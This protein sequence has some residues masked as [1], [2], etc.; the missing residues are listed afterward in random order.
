MAFSLGEPEFMSTSS[1]REYCQNGR[2]LIRP[3]ANELHI[4]SE[5]LKA[6]LKEVPGGPV[7]TRWR[8]RVV[9]AHLG[10]AAHGVELTCAGL[11]RTFL[12]FERHFINN[13]PERTKHFDLMR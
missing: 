3:L 8:A 7:E 6:A 13:T 9:A 12:S 2:N 5:E 4:A 1:L 11:V 10:N